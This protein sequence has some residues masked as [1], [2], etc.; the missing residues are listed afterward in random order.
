MR[1]SI[2][3]KVTAGF[4]SAVVMLL[5]LTGMGIGLAQRSVESQQWVTHTYVVLDSL[6][7]IAAGVYRASSNQ[8]AYILTGDQR[9]L[10][11]R[12]DA[13]HQVDSRVINVS[14]LTV[15]NPVQQARL[16]GLKKLIQAKLDTMIDQLAGPLGERTYAARRNLEKANFQNDSML[17]A[18]GAMQAEEQR[19]LSERSA[20][21]RHEATLVRIGLGGACLALLAFISVLFQRIN[22][23][24]GERQRAENETRAVNEQLFARGRKLET[25]IADLD[26]SK[27]VAER[28]ARLKDEFIGTVSHELR[29]P[30][31]ASRSAVNIVRRRRHAPE[32]ASAALDV[33]EQQIE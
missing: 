12:D 4:I 25:T 9:Y 17:A 32:E 16:L 26:R 31:A 14:E 3:H 27:E 21:V 19:L 1:L 11:D 18:V 10:L 6:G 29:T 8:R 33:L 30:L 13:L 28:A 2:T 24:M 5:A 7:G 22:R 15:D 20:A 23:E